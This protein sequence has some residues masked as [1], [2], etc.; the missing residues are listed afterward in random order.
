MDW[1]IQSPN[2]NATYTTLTGLEPATT[3]EVRVRAVSDHGNGAWSDT[4]NETT[5]VTEPSLFPLCDSVSLFSDIYVYIYIHIMHTYSN[6]IFNNLNIWIGFIVCQFCYSSILTFFYI[7]MNFLSS[8]I[9][10]KT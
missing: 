10:L 3:Y 9:L 8:L 7:I 5:C 6:I 1:T 4:V 2:P